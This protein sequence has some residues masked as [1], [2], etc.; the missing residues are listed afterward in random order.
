MPYIRAWLCSLPVRP[1]ECIEPFAGGGIVSL[2]VAF[3]H[4]A[5]HVT[6]VEL[7]DQVASIWQTLLSG[8]A[9]WLVERIVT[10]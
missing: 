2:T 4:L 8:D 3:E 1:A 7:D 5:D 9:A 10:L 6:M